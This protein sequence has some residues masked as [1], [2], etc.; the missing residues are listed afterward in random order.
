MKKSEN[1]ELMETISKAR[2]SLEHIF[3]IELP[4][5]STG[6][7]P[8]L[9]PLRAR[10]LLRWLV[11]C[12]SYFLAGLIVLVFHFNIGFMV[13]IPLAIAILWIFAMH[14]D[15]PPAPRQVDIKFWS[16]GSLRINSEWASVTLDDV[17]PVWVQDGL[18]FALAHDYEKKLES[19]GTSSAA[20]LPA[21]RG[22]AAKLGTD[23]WDLSG[24]DDSRKHLY[25]G[26]W[27]EGAKMD[28]VIRRGYTLALERSPETAT[29]VPILLGKFLE[30]GDAEYRDQP[31][32][33]IAVFNIAGLVGLSGKWARPEDGETKSHES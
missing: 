6:G 12:A 24:I 3:P 20:I 1:E 32:N 4:F 26:T 11:V 21:L 16:D 27:S 13:S 22:R 9:Q 29:P 18:V 25:P 15:L 2:S 19:G 17:G 31:L 14:R 23:S 5:D 30:N 10:P 33:S 28:E 8:G 7:K